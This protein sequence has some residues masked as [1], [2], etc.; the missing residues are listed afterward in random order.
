M[1]DESRTSWSHPTAP[2]PGEVA[3]AQADAVHKALTDAMPGVE[4]EVAR[5]LDRPAEQVVVAAFA[6]IVEGELV[7]PYTFALD[8]GRLD[9]TAFLA[10]L[11]ELI[12]RI[13]AVWLMQAIEDRE[14]KDG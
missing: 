10:S 3:Q 7:A 11:Q 12:R 4:A 1:A 9:P 2:H 13:T 6:Y 5:L 8:D 14:D